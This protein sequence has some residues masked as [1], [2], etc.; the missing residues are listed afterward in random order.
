MTT[1]VANSGGTLIAQFYEFVGGG[2]LVNLDA[3]P[4]IT[5]NDL[6]SGTTVLGPT[7][8]GV[9]NPA[10][11]TYGYPWTAPVPASQ[12]QAVWNGLYLGDAVQASEIFTVTVQSLNSN[13]PCAPWTPTWCVD[14]P[15]SAAAITGTMLMAATEILWAKSGRQ[16]STCSQT[17]R[18]CRKDCWGG[19]NP[20][21]QSW[22][23]YGAGW[24]YP[25][26]Y[27]GE[28][29]NLGCG[30]CAG[31][32]SCTVIHEVI[33]PMYVND[34]TEVKVDGV[35]LP[36]TSYMLYDHRTLLRVDGEEWPRCNDL[37]LEDTE[38]GT[39]SITFTTGTDVPQLGSLAVGEL[40]G[41]FILACV[42]DNTCAL[43]QPVQQLV[44]QGISMTF[45]DPNAV[46]AD[47]RVGLYFSDL[48]ISTFNP[49]GIAA[50]AQAFDVSN[51]RAWRRT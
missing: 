25:Y 32:C 41:Q 30:G 49:G 39:W 27:N 50:R 10:T 48:F 24:P 1:F 19:I 5:I 12:Y 35:V 51:T 13:G 47:G 3:T 6:N 40:A 31:S 34:I 43:P 29:F 26:N 33:L 16:F 15:L 21:S 9:T 44:R 45:L 18:P 42:G 8:V 14:I 28:W 20:F 2:P 7:A 23:E 17:L 22:N 36:S 38:V 46:F 37:N 11:G 4:T